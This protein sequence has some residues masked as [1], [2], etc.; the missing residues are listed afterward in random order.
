MSLAFQNYSSA[1]TWAKHLWSSPA[2]V[3]TS[4]NFVSNSW[5][6]MYFLIAII[7]REKIRCF[8]HCITRMLQNAG[9]TPACSV[10]SITQM[11][12]WCDPSKI[13]REYAT[14]QWR[15]CAALRVAN[16]CRLPEQSAIQTFGA[17]VVAKIY[18]RPGNWDYRSPSCFGDTAVITLIQLLCL[19]DLLLAK[20]ILI[21]T[22]AK[23]ISRADVINYYYWWILSDRDFQIAKHTSVSQR[24]IPAQM[25]KKRAGVLPS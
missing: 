10:Q 2:V 17:T 20:S 7:Y 16:Q 14:R 13:E 19:L 8:L 5:D 24:H 1:F 4:H 12:N 25:S 15:H 22:G 6:E 3:F 18:T 21:L 11:R 23:N 9:S